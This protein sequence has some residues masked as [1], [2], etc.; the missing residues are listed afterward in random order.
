MGRIDYDIKNKSFHQVYLLFGSESYMRIGYTHALVKALVPDE[1][2]MNFNK[3]EGEDVQEKD[4]ISQAETMPFFAD[5]RVILLEDTGFFAKSANDLADYVKKIPDYLVMIFSERK[6]DKRSRLYKAVSSAGIA[7]EYGEQSEDVLIRFIM[8]KIAKDK[9]KIKRSTMTRLL[10]LTSTDMTN[11]NN[12]TDKLLAYV[13]SPDRPTAGRDPDEITP[14]DLDAILTPELTDRIFDMV[15][16]VASHEQKK[17]LNLYYDLLALKEAPMKILSLLSRE[18]MQMYHVKE[19]SAAGKAPWEIAGK[20]G[21]PQFA[22]R[23]SL[24]ISRQYGR[25]EL[26][27][28]LEDFAATEEDVKTGR[29]GDRLAVEMLIIRYSSSKRAGAGK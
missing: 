1:D 20:V 11:I 4:V 25:G 19:L 17:A 18:Y 24:E 29:L 9:K 22:V 2:T 5:R 28:I 27:A 8:N 21:M 23:R 15:R 7:E 16:A 13:M 14:A 26:R 6:V 12:E 3:Y 10:Q